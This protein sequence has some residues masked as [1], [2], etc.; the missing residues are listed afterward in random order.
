MGASRYFS[1]KEDQTMWISKSV[2]I[3][4]FPE[5]FSSSDLWRVCNTYGK[6]VD[7]YIPLK[8]SKAGKKFAFVRFISIANL[9]R[10]I[11]NLC[12][13]WIGRLHL[14][15]NQV[16]FQRN[17]K[18]GSPVVHHSVGKETHSVGKETPSSFADILKNKSQ[19][20]KDACLPTVVLD[21]IPAI[22]L[23]ESCLVDKDLSC[24]VLGKIKDINALSNLY[25]LLE[26]E[27]SDKVHISY[28]GGYWVHIDTGSALSKENMCKHTGVSSWFSELRPAND[29]F[30]SDE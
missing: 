28:L 12:T 1:S 24:A 23:D 19:P 7:V 22:V 30:V 26:K 9:D 13:I 16:R 8:K 15:A 3:T 27:G 5:H 11:G 21:S 14:H 2:F 20:H 10:L 18:G 4:N 17:H 29:L 6:V 25:T